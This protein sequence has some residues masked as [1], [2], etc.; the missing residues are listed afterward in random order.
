MLLSRAQYRA[1]RLEDLARTHE[2]ALAENPPP[3]ARSLLLTNEGARLTAGGNRDEGGRVAK[4]AVA[5]AEVEGLDAALGA[6][7][8]S[9]SGRLAYEGKLSEAKALAH[10]GLDAYRRTHNELG[11]ARG[12]NVLAYI[13]FVEQDF[14]ACERFYR[15]GVERARQLRHRLALEE[16]L[17]GLAALLIQMGRWSE[18]RDLQA[19]SARVSLEDSRP[20]SLS[21]A[22]SNLAQIDGLTGRV[23]RARRRAIASVRIAR[24]C[25]RRDLEIGGLRSLAQVYR[26]SGRMRRAERMAREA[27][28]LALETGFAFEVEWCRIEFGRCC[29]KAGR[30]RE[31]EEVWTRALEARTPSGSVAQAILLALIGRAAARRRDFDVANT[32]LQECELWLTTHVV[33]YAT[34]HAMQLRAEI[35]LA[36]GRIEEGIDLGRR[37][38]AAFNELP[39]PPDRAMAALDFA[40]LAIAADVDASAPVDDWLQDAAETFGRLGDHPCREWALALSV[41]WLRR[42]RGV[43]GSSISRERGLIQSVS[44]LLDSLSDLTELTQRAMQMAVE[45]LDA[46]RGVLVLT[47]PT[48]GELVPVVERGIMD[49]V[50]RTRAM[51]FSHRAVERVARSGGPVLYKDAPSQPDAISESVLDLG[52]RS[53]VCVPLFVGGKVVGAVYLDDSRR[54]DTFS[55]EDRGLLEGFA[56]LIAIAIEKSRGQD[57]INRANEALLGENLSLRREVGGRFQP[58]NFVGTSTAMQQVL[59]IVER[60]AQIPA[61]V[62]LTGENGTGK[63]MIARILHHSG[64]R[65]LGSFVPVNCGAIPETLLESELFGI[66]ANVAT[67]VRPRDGRFVQAHGGTLFLDEIGDMPLKQQVALLMSI[68]SREIIP[69][70]GGQPI[71]VDVRI[72]AATNQDLRRKVEDGTFREDL[73]FRLNVIPIEIPPLRERKS[74]IPPLAHHF[75]SHFAQQQEREV[76]SLSP[77]FVA[78]LMQSEWAGNVRELQN[79]IERVMALTPGHVLYPDP[80]PRDLEARAPRVRAERGRRLSDLVADLE[81]RLIREAMERCGGNQSGAARELGLTEQSMRYRLKRYAMVRSRRNL[82]TRKIRR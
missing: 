61:T 8:M 55:M 18:G 44:R 45:Q 81:R 74:D 14:T 31:A 23:S 58:R 34:A 10:R 22:L 79:Y 73:F 39:A 68:S 78:A 19:E 16:L 42:H 72:I 27:L 1:N 66:L 43:G 5:L 13:A 64:K 71:P 77:E 41:D 9:Y 33:P 2:R 3:L 25:A 50:S 52:L 4:E 38:L 53:I 40:R 32:R 35:A 30:W 37:T 47:D 24:L 60:A 48:T 21:Q 49:G 59:A 54:P 6:A 57:E 15:E 82:R 20:V 62:L 17:V 67:G 65:R 80:L 46:E 11:L 12:F 28:A 63:E 51:T 36:D 76:P 7:A 56:H 26:I 69:V 70:G 75:A 29:A